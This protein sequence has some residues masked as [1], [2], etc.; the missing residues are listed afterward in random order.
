M[1]PGA[2]QDFGVRPNARTDVEDVEAAL[3]TIEQKLRGGRARIALVG[4]P[5]S[6]K[7]RLLRALSERLWPDW[8]CVHLPVPSLMPRDIR[9]WVADFAGPLPNDPGET[10]AD[11]ARAFARSSIPLVLLIDD[12]HAM[13]EEVAVALEETLASADGALVLVLA[14]LDSPSS[15]SVLAAF[16]H[17]F[18]SV[19]L[20][21]APESSLPDREQSVPATPAPRVEA[22]DERRPRSARAPRPLRRTG[23]GPL[24]QAAAAL[25]LLAVGFLMGRWSPLATRRAE[26]TPPP[27]Q[28][29][30]PSAPGAAD[31]VEVPDPRAIAQTTAP[32]SQEI[33]V[34]VNAKPWAHIAIDG[35]DT[36]DTPL[37]NLPIAPGL[38]RFRAE[39]PDGRVIE[40]V[41]LI[42]AENRRVSF[43]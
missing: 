32:P 10:L 27:V 39:L 21:P 20:A 25:C 4:P 17:A 1:E 9:A 35:S 6:G 8:R 18:D 40:R 41:V 31:D 33:L 22:P 24:L 42:D 30:P 26:P 2:P 28:S 38:H 11:L 7:T 5:G 15:A 34:H 12:A 14:F 37:G 16:T 23:R 29:G 3:D 36:G 43:P 19:A 13:P